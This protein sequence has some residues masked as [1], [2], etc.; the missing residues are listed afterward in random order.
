MDGRLAAEEAMLRTY[1]ASFGSVWMM[2]ANR[3]ALPEFFVPLRTTFTATL[4][5]VGIA[6]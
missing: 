6:N 4:G 3:C 1:L 2:S 5:R